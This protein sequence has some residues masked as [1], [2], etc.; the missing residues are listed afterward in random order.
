[1]Y[2][3]ATLALSSN[4]RLHRNHLMT[5]RTVSVSTAAFL[6]MPT[7][8]WAQAEAKPGSFGF[9]IEVDGEGS[10]LNPTLKSVTIKSVVSGR[11]AAQ[12]DIKPGDQILEVDGKLVAGAKARDLEPHLRKNVGEKLN[13]RLRRQSGDIYSATLVA[14]SKSN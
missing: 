3:L 6:A 4:V 7:S 11:P 5:R 12:A 14:A 1:M 8:I 2:I 9:A 10:F 13:L